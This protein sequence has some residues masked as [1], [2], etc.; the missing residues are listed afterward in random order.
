MLDVTTD[1][2]SDTLCLRLPPLDMPAMKACVCTHTTINIVAQCH[3]TVFKRV[4]PHLKGGENIVKWLLI[5][6]PYYFDLKK[7]NW[8]KFL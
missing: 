6:M 4:I 8:A 5:S 7:V 3:R 1:T 2:M